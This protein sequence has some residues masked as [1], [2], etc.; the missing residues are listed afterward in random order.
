MTR[1]VFVGADDVAAR[2][3]AEPTAVRFIEVRREPNEDGPARHLPDAVV[4]YLTEDL[5]RPD[6][7]ATDGKRPLPGVGALQAALRRWGI[8]HGTSVIVYDY[9]G[10]FVAARA[11]WVLRWAGIPDV[12]ILDGGLPA[13][14]AAGHPTGPLATDVPEGDVTVTGGHLSQLDADGSA[15]LAAEG[16]LVDA[17]TADAFREGHIPGARHVGSGAT[18]GAD[19]TLRDDDTLRAIYGV[20]DGGSNVPGLYCGGG[21]A[22]AH[23]VA[24][25]AHLGIAAP[26][27]VGSFSAWS[28]DPARPVAKDSIDV[29]G[30]T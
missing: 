21:V 3:R 4:A 15:A 14:L 7:P 26:L 16:R 29:G 6:A 9:D 12:G 22:A 17:R 25:L 2:L 28:A 20:D 24:A 11:W 8:S 13:W 23:A 10:S 30:V 19:G 5:S 18:V 1:P 27:Y